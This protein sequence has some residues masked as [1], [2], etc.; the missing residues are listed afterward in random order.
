[1]LKSFRFFINAVEEYSRD[2]AVPTLIIFSSGR[3]AFAKRIYKNFLIDFSSWCSHTLSCFLYGHGLFFWSTFVSQ[4]GTYQ[5]KTF[6]YICSPLLSFLCSNRFFKCSSRKYLWHRI[7]IFH[8]LFT[9]SVEH[10]YTASATSPMIF[11]REKQK[12]KH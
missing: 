10:F 7:E 1:M 11:Q 6:L 2:I 12:E 8:G 5:F 4:L 9:F 3:F